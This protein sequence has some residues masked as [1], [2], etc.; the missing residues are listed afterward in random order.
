MNWLQWKWNSGL[1]LLLILATISLIFLDIVNF[2][3]VPIGAMKIPT[4]YFNSTAF[5]VKLCPPLPANLK[6]KL[7]FNVSNS[8]PKWTEIEAENSQ[9]SFG[10]QY[11]PKNCTAR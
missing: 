10:G 7:V 11:E 4:P 3:T 9:N 8:P 2:T 6:G 1:F 5:S